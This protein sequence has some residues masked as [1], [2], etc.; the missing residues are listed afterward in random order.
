MTRPT[1]ADPGPGRPPRR[2]LALGT[3]GRLTWLEL[4]L[5]LREP[6]TVVFS[7]ALP[8]VLLFVLGGVFSNEATQPGEEVVWRGVGAMN[9]YVPAYLA[10]VSASVALISIPTQLAGSRERGVL[11]RYRA[12]SLRAVDVVAA[13]ALVAMVVSAVSAVVLLVAA[14]PAYEFDGPDSPLAV[15]GTFV[16]VMAGFAVFGVFL[17]SVMPTARTAQAAGL[18]AW[19]VMLLVGGAGPPAEVMTDAMRQVRDVTPL[20]YAVKMLHQ[21]WLDLDPGLA[22]PVFICFLAASSVASV[23][24]FRWE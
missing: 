23:V 8:L 12:S 20:W 1:T 19:F 24:F 14:V 22:W 13:N 3:V 7:L 21:G 16:V 2:G 10:L 6:L 5:M 17:G 11:R 15:L 4:K 9:F 18:I